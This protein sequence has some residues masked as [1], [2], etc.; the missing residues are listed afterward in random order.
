MDT[1]KEEGGFLYL[2][3]E[4]SYSSLIAKT[5]GSHPKPLFLPPA[6]EAFREEF[7]KTRVFRP[8]KR[9]GGKRWGGQSSLLTR[10]RKRGRTTNF[11]KN[12]RWGSTREGAFQPDFLAGTGST[13][14]RN[15]APPASKRTLIEFVTEKK[16][17]ERGKRQSVSSFSEN[18]RPRFKKKVVNT[19]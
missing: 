10:A 3:A 19:P 12:I 1:V 9:R 5:L 2:R 6:G 8:R 4:V 16:E 17:P 11:P 18:L 14:E 7:R 13:A 15:L